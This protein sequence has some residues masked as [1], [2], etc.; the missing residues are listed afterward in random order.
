MKKVISLSITM[1]LVL[2][3]VTGCGCNKKEKENKKE[4]VKVNTNKDVVKDQEVD[5]IK[6]TNTSLVTTNGISKL[7]TNVTN[8]STKDYKLDEYI[9]IIK[10]KKGEEIVRIPG[11]VGDTIKAGETRTINSSVDR[12][13]SNA[14]S[15]EYEVKK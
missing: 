3:L 13:L 11:Y 15:I 14:G 10:D 1:L 4:E 12:D 5:G 2:G 6:M 8:S 9:I 7:V